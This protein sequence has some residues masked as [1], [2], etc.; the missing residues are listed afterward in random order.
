[1]EINNLLRKINEFAKAQNLCSELKEKMK[2]IKTKVYRS[3]M[4][5]KKENNCV[6]RRK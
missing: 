2:D 5:S 1:M 6:L 4:S 3:Y